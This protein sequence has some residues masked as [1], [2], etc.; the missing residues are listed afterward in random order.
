MDTMVIA[1]QVYN[2]LRYN[3]DKVFAPTT[4]VA[5]FTDGIAVNAD[6]PYKTLADYLKAAKADRQV[7]ALG[8]SGLGSEPHFLACDFTRQSGADMPI[9]PFQGGLAMDTTAWQP[10]RFGH[11]WHRRA[12]RTPSQPQAAHSGGVGTPMTCSRESWRADGSGKYL[13]F[14]RHCSM[15]ADM[16]DGEQP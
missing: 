1:P 4:S 13:F 5:E 8:V 9:I 3:P 15:G 6:A 7:A 14:W 10:D 12:S 2:H 16:A 11:R